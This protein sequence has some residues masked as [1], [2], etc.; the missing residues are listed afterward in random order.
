MITPRKVLNILEAEIQKEEKCLREIEERAESL[1]ARAL[2]RPS[3]FDLQI[4]F[5]GAQK[6]LQQQHGRLAALADLRTI[7]VTE[8]L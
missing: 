6:A 4:E 7:L 3:A 1:S 8:G 5:Q 2:A